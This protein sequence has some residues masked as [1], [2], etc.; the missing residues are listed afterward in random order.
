MGEAVAADTFDKAQQQLRARLERRYPLATR[1]VAVA[2][3]RLPITV[4][5]DPDQVLLEMEQGIARSGRDEPRWQPYWADSWESAVGLGEL[6]GQRDLAGQQ[7]LDLGCGMG[8]AG[9]VA[10]ARGAQVLFADAAPPSLLF[11]RWN[12]WPWRA[13]VD[14]RCVDWQRDDLGRRFELILGADIL[15]DSA[16]WPHL[17]RFW[18]RHLAAGGEVLLGEPSRTQSNGFPTWIQDQGWRLQPSIVDVAVRP[19]RI[20]IWSL[21]LD[22]E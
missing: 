2:E 18:R 8:L 12:S 4:V 15:Y 16:D 17:D 5:A 7:V 14:A 10:A 3:L 1:E 13:R 9:T 20:R 21:Q 11:A 22:P 6:L 19:R